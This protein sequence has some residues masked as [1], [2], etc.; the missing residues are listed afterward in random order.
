MR[1]NRIFGMGSIALGAGAAIGAGLWFGA[2]STASGANSED[3]HAQGLG[4]QARPGECVQAAIYHIGQPRSDAAAKTREQSV[5]RAQ[6]DTYQ[7]GDVQPSKENPNRAERFET[8]RKV[9]AV[10]T[11]P[12]TA[13]D[14][15]STVWY[16][17]QTEFSAPC[18]YVNQDHLKAAQT[19]PEGVTPA[20]AEDAAKADTDTSAKDPAPPPPPDE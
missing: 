4:V 18:D 5:K 15:K 1:I 13:T 16:V 6:M 17:T 8:G 2:A 3:P 10:E 11:L 9:A 20:R 14:D 12:F 19:I 7:L